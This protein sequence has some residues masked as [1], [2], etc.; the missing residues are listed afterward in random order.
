MTRVTFP[1]VDAHH[2]IWRQQ[3]LPWLSGPMLPRIFGP[4]EPIRRDY[5]ISEFRAEAQAA[6]V[7]AS[8]YVQTNWAPDTCV[9]EVA[10]VESIASETGWPHAIVGFCDLHRA[11]APSVLDKMLAA[12]PRLRG[13]RQQLHWH[14]N[15]QYRFAARPDT[16]NDPLWRNNLAAVAERGLVF[17]LQVFMGQAEHAENLVA[18]FP[19]LTFILT[20]AGM[21][22][23]LTPDG[24]A[25]WRAGLARLAAHPN[26]A[27]KLSG[28]GTFIHCN[29][30][31]HVKT[32]VHET[33]QTFG[34]DRCLFGSNF[35][36][37]KLWTD[38]GS[39]LADHLAATEA[40][41][42]MARAAIFG[43]TATRLYRLDLP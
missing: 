17:D 36:I 26:V 29:D 8:I 12:S 10:W 41:P 33:V 27:V 35:P 31:A 34:P 20:H 28:F 30:A 24:M 22:E 6:G 3:D 14:E 2:H 32:I 37:E 38:Y 15:P 18:A 21:P 9:D 11:D 5:P 16:M 23:E 7:V 40:Y 25:H 42:T 39:L 43:G 1:I 19:G 4:Y 13:I